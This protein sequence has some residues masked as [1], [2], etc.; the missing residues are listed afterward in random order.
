MTMRE[1]G[2]VLA[3]NSDTSHRAPDAPDVS[4]PQHQHVVRPG[5]LR[6]GQLG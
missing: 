2:G 6:A 4:H 3:M 1:F 5:G